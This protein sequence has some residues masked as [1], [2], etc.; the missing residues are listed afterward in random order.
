MGFLLDL[1]FPPKCLLCNS[2]KVD[3]KGLC[4]SCLEAWTKEGNIL[5]PGKA[6]SRCISAGWYRDSLRHALLQFKFSL[7]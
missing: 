2:R 4:S 1:L 3:R 6:F 7:D 5:T